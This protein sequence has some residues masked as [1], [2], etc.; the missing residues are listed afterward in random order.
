ML[1]RIP[2]SITAMAGDIAMGVGQVLSD[3]AVKSSIIA[4]PVAYGLAATLY[5][6][7]YGTSVAQGFT[8][9]ENL[10]PKDYVKMFLSPLVP[11][12]TFG[13]TVDII[14]SFAKGNYLE[15]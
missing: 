1:V 11:D 8:S 9:Q 13:T 7:S 15:G 6:V 5:M 3:A 14:D 10:E 2:Y 4:G 12:P